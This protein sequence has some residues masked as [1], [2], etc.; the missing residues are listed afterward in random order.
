MGLL[1]KIFKRPEKGAVGEYFQAFTGYAPVFTT[2]EG[3]LYEMALT[4]AAIN[5]IATQCGKLI[6]AVMGAARPDLGATLEFRPNP[7]MGTPKYIRRLVTI[8]LVNNTAFIVPIE[9]ERG[10]IAGYF[11]IL[12]NNAEVKEYQNTQFLRYWFSN[13]QTAAIEFDRVGILTRYQYRDDFFGESNNVMDTTMQLIHANNE[14]I[15]NGIKNSAFIRF[16]AKVNN[17]IAPEDITAE[18]KRF[19]KDNL[20][21]EN[22]SGVIIYDNKF[23]ELKEIQSKPF[24]VSAAQ[25]ELIE[26][27]VFNYFGVNKKILQA[28]YTEAEWGAFYEGTIEPIAI[29]LSIAHTN[30][31]FTPR[32]VACGNKIMFSTNRLQ[33]ASNATKLNVSTQLFDRGLLN[34][35]GVMD[36]W[37]M[38]HVEGGEKYYIRK[39]YTEVGKLGKEGAENADQNGTGIQDDGADGGDAAI[40]SDEAV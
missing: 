15:K 12:P 17:M 19:T 40:G 24:I 16:L 33:Y 38:P 5:V 2:Y 27:N 29:D 4:R 9:D 32:M 7:W 35:N 39:E 11:P 28:D 22:Q 30:M 14:G 25:A 6:P 37:N 13:G 8:L 23:S 20:S 3:G 26:A 31:T 10:R 36:I 34:R 18:R 1:E 21:A